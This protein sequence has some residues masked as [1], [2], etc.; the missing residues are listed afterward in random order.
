MFDFMYTKEFWMEVILASA[1]TGIFGVAIALISA[2]VHQDKKF[3]KLQFEH[4]ALCEKNKEMREALSKEHEV[5][6]EALNK[7]HDEL[8]REHGIISASIGSF[9][10]AWHTRYEKEQEQYYNL[11]H[12]QKDISDAVKQI[13]AMEAE[14]KRLAEAERLAREKIKELEKQVMELQIEKKALKQQLIK[15]RSRDEYE[16]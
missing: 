15:E 6:Q 9:Q 16:R 7:E 8:R 10:T 4:K 1:I 12:E 13:T 14:M 2:Y 11:S 3:Q 5:M